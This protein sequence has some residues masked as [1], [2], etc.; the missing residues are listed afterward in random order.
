MERFGKS[1][2]QPGFPSF[3]ASLGRVVVFVAA[4]LLLI[5]PQWASGASIRFRDISQS[6]GV[7][8]PRS[9]FPEKRFIVEMMGGGVALFDCDND[10]KLDIVVVNDSSVEENLHGG[11]L[12]VTL[13]H[14]DS[15]LHFSDTTVQSGLTTRGWGM[16]VTIGDFDNDGLPDIFVTGYGHNVFIEISAAAS[17]KM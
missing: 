13:Y 16:G 5:L 7:D 10:G 8:S 4:T 6:S 12:M 2:I 17:L 15:N 3:P 11:S 9:S 1:W 14:Q